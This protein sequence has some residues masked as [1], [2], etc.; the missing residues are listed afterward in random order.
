MK[1]LDWVLDKLAEE[2]CEVA[3]AAIKHK[4]KQTKKS[5][6]R[7]SDEM[8]QLLAFMSEVARLG[9]SDRHRSGQECVARMEVIRK[10]FEER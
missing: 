6:R 2:A 10:R 5:R 4:H 9:L 1:N 3:Q 8:G 7:L